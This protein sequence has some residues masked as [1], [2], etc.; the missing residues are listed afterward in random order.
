MV[1]SGR[2]LYV[3]DMPPKPPATWAYTYRLDPPQD[4]NRL[5]SLR[6]LL[7]KEHRASASRA[8]R[9]KA[10]LVADDRVSHILVVTDSPDLTRKENLRLEAE[11]R[12]LRAEFSVTIPMAFDGEPDGDYAEGADE[13]GDETVEV[14]P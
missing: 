3:A 10:R 5:K 9:W 14:A 2:D 8:E 11:L 7:A 13:E 12:A 6:A 4:A 1:R